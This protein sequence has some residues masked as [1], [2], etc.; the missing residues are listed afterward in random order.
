MGVAA[1]TGSRRQLE[2]EMNITPLVD[3]VLVL[4]IIFMVVA[5]QLE[6]GERVELPAVT[7]PD[8]NAKGKL[9]PITVTVAAGGALFI[10]KER[11]GDLDALRGR[12]EAIHASEPDRRVVVKG[13]STLKYATMR[14]AFAACQK[15]GFAGVSLSVNQR[16]KVGAEE[17]G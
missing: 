9:D 2:P 7:N 17:G 6:Q 3:V 1:G 4:L 8:K 5:P 10:E 14:E 13:D 16:G 12:L 11:F 15:I